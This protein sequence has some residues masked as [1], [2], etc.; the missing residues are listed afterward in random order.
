M[1]GGRK[2]GARLCPQPPALARLQ[3]QG[4]SP[5]PCCG[6]RATE[7]GGG[8]THPRVSPKIH[9]SQ[10]ALSAGR[11]PTPLARQ[12]SFSSLPK[13]APYRLRTCPLLTTRSP[14][15]PHALLL[16]RSCSPCLTGREGK[17]KLLDKWSHVF[18]PPN[19]LLLSACL[20]WRGVTG[21]FFVITVR[22]PAGGKPAPGDPEKLWLS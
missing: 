17:Q 20:L 7:H 8:H 22:R 10:R 15:P 18:R 14:Q 1:T 11:P 13:A 5:W 12:D 16:H 19:L 2:A 21:P 4:N 6:L 9:G 3:L